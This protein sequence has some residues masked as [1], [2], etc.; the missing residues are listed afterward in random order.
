MS[1]STVV[2]APRIRWDAA[3]WAVLG[4]CIAA[5]LAVRAS[6]YHVQTDD[7]KYFVSRWYE[8][9]ARNGGFH[10]LKYDLSNYNPP[11]LYLLTIATYIPLSELAAIKTVSVVF[12][13]VLAAFAFLIFRLKYPRATIPVVG[14][15][16]VFLAPTVI[17]NG[18]AWGQCDAIYT[19]FCL[20]SLYFLLTDRP[21]WA[22]IFF[23]LACS[24]KLQAVF[25]APVLILLLL[26]GK[27]SALCLLLVPVTCAVLLLPAIVAGRDV[28]SLLHIYVDQVKTG[29]M[30]P[31]QMPVTTGSPASLSG[32][33]IGRSGPQPYRGTGN[34]FGRGPGAGA[35]PD[36]V[37]MVADR[38]VRA[39]ARRVRG[40]AVRAAARIASRPPRS[41]STPHPSTSGS[42][43]RSSLLEMDWNLPCRVVR[44]DAGCCRVSLQ[45]QAD[46]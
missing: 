44:R 39:C 11:Y 32:S 36:L 6:V 8:F 21:A 25:F 31:V 18:A 34:G 27:R 24:F 23:G 10:A 28:Q 37:G 38:L 1:M 29:G 41:P 30:T 13:V 22:A 26:R 12:D 2:R 33:L 45:E 5:G 35:A 7:Y 17:V 4:I 9:L 42:G 43:R 46:A 20:G 3:R 19:A 40:R 16:V 15:L 14:A